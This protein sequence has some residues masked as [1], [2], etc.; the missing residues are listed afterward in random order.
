LTR[1]LAA[2][3]GVLAI[4][5][6]PATAG[7]TPSRSA[8]LFRGD[9]ERPIRS[10]WSEV[11]CERTWSVNRVRGP[12]AQGRF[13]ARFEVRTGDENKDYRDNTNDSCE[14]L[15]NRY[16]NM[17]HDE[18]YGQSI[19]FPKSWFQPY[20]FNIITQYNYVGV[21]GPPIALET[22]APHNLDLTMETGHVE[23]PP[24]GDDYCD[25]S[26]IRRIHI[27]RNLSLGHW[28]DIILHVR[29]SARS[30]GILELWHRVEGQGP[31]RK[32]ITLRNIPTM[33]WREDVLLQNG[34]D[35]R[36]GKPHDGSDKIGLYRGR[37]AGQRPSFLWHDNFRVGRSFAAIR[38][39][40]RH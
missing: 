6:T 30:N 13:A 3:V 16:V 9:F 40:F 11:Q 26:Y 35:P 8:F 7:S 28:H 15:R 34:I 20:W 10:Q 36:T 23:L 24:C 33:Q 31:F 17:G 27:T 38:A 4:A 32:I 12:A 21:T 18:Y 37:R 5:L 39:G 19:R 1:A 22:S 25:G 29:W 2:V 14:L